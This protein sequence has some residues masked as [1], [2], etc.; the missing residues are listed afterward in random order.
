MVCPSLNCLKHMA[1]R[2]HR[3]PD[4]IKPGVR[5]LF[6]GI[7]PGLRS[8]ATGHHF[9]GYSNRFWKLLYESGLVSQPLSYADDWRLPEWQLGLTNI[10]GRC[11]RGVEALRP[12][13][14]RKG[15]RTLERKIRRFKP[16]LVV[17][18]GVTIFRAFFPFASQP[19]LGKTRVRL[20]GIPVYL[21][22]N[23]SG[24]NAHYTY[25][26]MLRGFCGLRRLASGRH[27]AC[28]TFSSRCGI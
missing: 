8:G 12:H 16:K 9:A 27:D 19:R 1:R 26:A 21:L 14:Y 28:C 11:T 22:A 23:P 2:T 10:I 5:I 15:L 20:G 17:L 25:A 7:N 13:E 6:V 4:H 24:R 3:L 18:L